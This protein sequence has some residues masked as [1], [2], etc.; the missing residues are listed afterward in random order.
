MKNIEKII[1]NVRSVLSWRLI[2]TPCGRIWNGG[3][4]DSPAARPCARYRRANDL[5]RGFSGQLLRQDP[6]AC[7]PRM[8][9]TLSSSSGRKSGRRPPGLEK[10]VGEKDRRQ[11]LP[12]DIWPASSLLGLIRHDV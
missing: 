8:W 3:G 7:S 10:T 9:S 11:K 4:S 1:S 2:N 6:S 5:S 12:G